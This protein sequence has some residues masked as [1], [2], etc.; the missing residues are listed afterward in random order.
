MMGV[1]YMIVMINFQNMCICN[2]AVAVFFRFYIN[3]SL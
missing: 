1:V 3:I 2:M